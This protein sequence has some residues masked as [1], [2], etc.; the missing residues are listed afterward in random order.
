MSGLCECGCGQQAPLARKTDNRD[1]RRKG[2][3]LRFVRGH[4]NVGRRGKNHGS[5]KGGRV[6]MGG[7]VYVHRPEHPHASAR[8][9]VAEHVLVA[10]RVLGKQ[11]P[12]GAEVHHVNG[13]KTDNRTANLVICESKGYHRML[14]ERAEALRVY[15]NPNWRKCTFCKHYGDPAS[16]DMY[17]RQNARKAYHRE[18]ERKN[19]RERA[20][21]LRELRRRGIDP[22]QD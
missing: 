3:A 7:Y 10:S 5:W 4:E 20:A 22:R 18:C 13:D 17:V 11:L 19:Q 2:E 9:Y 14:H 8:G 21:V 16:G 6:M 12:P 15:G 1:G